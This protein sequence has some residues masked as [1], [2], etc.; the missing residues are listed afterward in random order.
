MT[1]T[2]LDKIAKGEKPVG[3]VQ[4]FSGFLDKLKPQLALALPRH[5]NA[6]RMARLVLTQYSTTPALRECTSQSIAGCIMIAAQL[7]LEPG[8]NKPLPS[9]DERAD[10]SAAFPVLVWDQ[11]GVAVD[12]WF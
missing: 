8:I 7:G 5:M 10:C 2:T 11:V 4:K 1:S 9:G 12:A 6:D 3:A